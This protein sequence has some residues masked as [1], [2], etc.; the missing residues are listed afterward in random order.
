MERM[1]LDYQRQ[2]ATLTLKQALDEYYRA[3]PHLLDINKFTNET[4]EFF[5]CHD[6]IHVIFGCD[7]SFVGEAKADFWTILG[8]DIGFKN[9]LKF[10]TSPIVRDLL[11]DIRAK[12][13][14]EAKMRLRQDIR[15]NFFQALL[16][17]VTVYFKARRMNRKWP[18]KNSDHLLD[19]PLYEL[20]REFG[21][22]IF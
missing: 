13:T 1:N 11:Q 22:E 20:R 12:M 19:R 15:R 14:A 10:A 7:T 21:I 6:R 9:Y 16:T 18:W 8:A 3:N 4:G 5:R 17:P 2:D